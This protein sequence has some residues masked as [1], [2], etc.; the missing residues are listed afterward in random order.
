MGMGTG[1]HIWNQTKLK[2][3]K[4]AEAVAMMEEG[5][6]EFPDGKPRFANED[7]MKVHR[8]VRK[9]A[10]HYAGYARES[11]QAYTNIFNADGPWHGYFQERYNWHKQRLS[12]GFRKALAEL[13]EGGG[14]LETMSAKLYES[15]M[16]ELNDPELAKK[17]PF[18]ERAALYRDVTKLAAQVKG[19]S[20]T[21]HKPQVTQPS[22]MVGI[23][24]KLPEG[25]AKKAQDKLEV[26]EGELAE[27]E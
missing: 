8:V 22:V 7:G 18:R 6:F 27:S 19:E 13:T 26:I 3:D 4:V 1:D 17:I 15:L 21:R 16:Y 9:D 14:A 10:M 23:I 24:N 20:E 5:Q 11:Q 12:G 2:I 25:V